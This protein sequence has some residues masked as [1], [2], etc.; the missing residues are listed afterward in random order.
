[1]TVFI[2]FRRFLTVAAVIALGWSGFHLY[3]AAFG[4][5]HSMVFRPIHVALATALVFAA[6]PVLRHYRKRGDNVLDSTEPSPEDLLSEEDRRRFEPRWITTMDLV[7]VVASLGVGGYYLIHSQRIAERVTFIDEVLVSDIVVGLS[8]IVLV[9]E[10]CRRVV[11]LSLSIVALVFLGYQMW[12]EHLGGALRHSGLNL[13][14]FIDL[15]FLSPQGMFGT[16]VGVSADYVFYFILFAAFLEF[17]GGG[18]LFI[19]M[20]MALTGRAKGGAAKASVVGSALMG[21]INGSAVANVVGTGVFTI[22]LMKRMGFKARFAAGVEAMASTG[23]QLLPPIMGAGAFIMAQML[24]MPYYEVI[25]AALIPSLLYFASGFIMV[26]KQARKD[27][28]QPLPKG[29]RTPLR[30]TLTRLHLLIPLGYLVY[31]ILSGRSLMAAAFEAIIAVVLVGFL[32]RQTWFTPVTVL[33]ALENGARRAVAVALPCALAGIVVGVIVQTNL[34]R[35]FT[36]LVLT[37][38]GGNLVAALVVVMVATIIVGMG[39]PTTSAYIMGAVLM[40]P[41]LIE[42]G[43]PA[44]AAHLF[45]FYFACLSMITPPVALAAFAAAGIAGSAIARTAVTAFLISLAAFLVPYAFVFS[46]ALLMQGGVGQTVWVTLT[47]LLGVYALAGA[48]IGYECGRLGW[49]SRLLLLAS[50]CAL[51]YPGYLVSGIAV[52]VVGVFIAMQ[53]IRRRKHSSDRADSKDAR[54]ASLAST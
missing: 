3:A 48:V 8:L 33:A 14:R 20:A 24:G 49:R 9:L 7:L 19:D 42:L 44:L 18:K 38:S 32:R 10:A 40:A 43:V 5:P 31:M 36:D 52:L 37:L 15:Q 39:M 46:P 23:G 16:P 45:I 27:D 11:G 30:D 34:G 50:A 22:P 1:M 17:S 47:A 54:D 2:Q 35:R 25:I 41:P 12:G 13:D 6:Y 51:I 29:E 53:T 4:T 28:L 26:D 21:S